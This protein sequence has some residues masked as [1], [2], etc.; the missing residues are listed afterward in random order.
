MWVRRGDRI[1]SYRSIIQAIAFIVYVPVLLALKS[2]VNQGRL[3]KAQNTN[4][5]LMY[6][7]TSNC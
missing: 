5:Y 1:L 2:I 4:R 7:H 3:T 6:L